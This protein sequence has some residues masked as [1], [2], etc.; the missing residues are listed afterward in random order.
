MNSH[1]MAHHMTT[2]PNGG[3][4]TLD[5][6]D[7]P[8]TGYYIGGLVSPL[9]VDE[10]TSAG[11]VEYF[12]DYLKSLNTVTHVQWQTDDENAAWVDGVSW[13]DRYI[14][15]E[16]TC[17]ERGERAFYDIERTRSFTPIVGLV[18]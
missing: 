2:N 1:D 18:P 17:K 14:D 8:T 7:V 15:A 9:I 4:F 11:D 13:T 16:V 3:S 5:G 12:I 10:M 6:S